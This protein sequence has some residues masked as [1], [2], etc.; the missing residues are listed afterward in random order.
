[1]YPPGRESMFLAPCR[2]FL[3]KSGDMLEI[4]ALQATLNSGAQGHFYQ[5]ILSS[6]AFRA[7][8]E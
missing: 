8:H 5:A 2:L 6:D 3:F 4:V 7:V 1:M